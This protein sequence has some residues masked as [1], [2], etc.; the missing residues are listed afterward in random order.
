MAEGF[1]K[2]Y[3][4]KERQDGLTKIGRNKW[5]ARFGYGEDESGNGYNYVQQ[6]KGRKPTLAELKTEILA[7]VDANTD[8][9]ILQ[10]YSYDGKLV[11][12]SSENQFNYKAAYDLAVQ[13]DGASLPFKIK[14]GSSSAP[15]YISFSDVATFREFYVA[16]LSHIQ[17]CLEEGWTEKDGIEW[18]KYE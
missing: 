15:S 13:T 4:A 6:F 14:V 5:E 16:A 1:D 2:I 9:R 12:L 7:L 17:Q 8:E 11:W 3:G 18:E 10:G